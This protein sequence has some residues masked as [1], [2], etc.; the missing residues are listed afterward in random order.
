MRRI[1]ELG[2]YGM[3]GAVWMKP[4]EFAIECTPEIVPVGTNLS[5]VILANERSKNRTSGGAKA[6]PEA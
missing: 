6:R 3:C 5:Y 1:T 4:T 2:E